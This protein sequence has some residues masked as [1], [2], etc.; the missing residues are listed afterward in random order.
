LEIQAF[1][2]FAQRAG[3]LADGARVVVQGRLGSQLVCDR[4]GIERIRMYV[5]AETI[6][7]A[8]IEDH[9]TESAGV[10]EGENQ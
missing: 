4:R 8:P 1:G 10:V 9:V 7:P 5:N 2:M 6:E 3:K